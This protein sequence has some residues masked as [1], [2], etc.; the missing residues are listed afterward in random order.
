MFH[1]G[2]SSGQELRGKGRPWGVETGGPQAACAFSVQPSI[3]LST[4]ACG[5]A[6]QICQCHKHRHGGMNMWF[7]QNAWNYQ[8]KGL[9]WRYTDNHISKRGCGI[10][11]GRLLSW[12]FSTGY[13][14]LVNIV[15]TQRWRKTLKLRK[16]PRRLTPRP[17]IDKEI[18]KFP[19]SLRKTEKVFYWRILQLCNCWA[20]PPHSLFCAPYSPTHG[21][22]HRLTP[23]FD[24]RWPV[25]QQNMKASTEFSS[26]VSKWSV[27]L[28]GGENHVPRITCIFPTTTRNGTL[29]PLCTGES[30]SSSQNVIN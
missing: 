14:L 2:N 16:F 30:G 28:V 26:G 24:T 6:A 18:V 25:R 15:G 10:N 13:H 22:F 19:T 12:L 23:H 3:L 20:D 21:I 7:L 1:W 9:L 4:S 29:F 11:P 27:E 17:Y 8:Q 5:S